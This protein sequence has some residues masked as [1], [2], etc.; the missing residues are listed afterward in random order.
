MKTGMPR[1]KQRSVDRAYT[2]RMRRNTAS[3]SGI[4]NVQN[5]AAL[6]RHARP[7]LPGI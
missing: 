1:H 2:P 6:I 3:E 4:A 7:A 5:A